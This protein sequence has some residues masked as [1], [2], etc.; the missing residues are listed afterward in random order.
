MQLS[1]F[2]SYGISS[3]IVNQDTSDDSDNS[4]SEAELGHMT[5][6]ILQKI[7]YQTFRPFLVGVTVTSLT[8]VA[9]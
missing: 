2:T 8:L 3:V 5:H 4:Y 1:E 7:A 6:V 9:H